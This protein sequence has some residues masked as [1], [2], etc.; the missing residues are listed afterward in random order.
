MGRLDCT[1]S[2][3]PKVSPL[4]FL[5][6]FLYANAVVTEFAHDVT[7]AGTNAITNTIQGYTAWTW[8]GTACSGLGTP[9]WLG[10]P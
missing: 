1:A 5:N 2:I 9:R 7:L 10:D 4:G 6:P 3:K 8:L